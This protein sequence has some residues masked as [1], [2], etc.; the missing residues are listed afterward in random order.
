MRSETTRRMFDTASRLSARGHPTHRASCSRRRSSSPSPCSASENAS[1]SCARRARRRCRSGDC[2]VRNVERP[3]RDGTRQVDNETSA[4]VQL[5][6]PM[7]KRRT[8]RASRGRRSR[9]ARRRYGNGASPS[10]R[11]PTGT[12]GAIIRHRHGWE[13]GKVHAVI[14]ADDGTWYTAR[15]PKTGARYQIRHTRD[16]RPQATPPTRRTRPG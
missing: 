13:D 4:G 7:T 16:F 1:T 14:I 2:G 15:D 11:H 10:R 8:S 6:A 3:C 5:W 12:P 9:D